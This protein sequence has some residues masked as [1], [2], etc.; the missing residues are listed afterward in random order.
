MR[1]KTYKEMKAMFRARFIEMKFPEPICKG[2][3]FCLICGNKMPSDKSDCKN[4][5]KHKLMMKSTFG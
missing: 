2:K 3:I 4:D 1:Q 5:K